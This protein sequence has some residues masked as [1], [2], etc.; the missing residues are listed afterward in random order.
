MI[1]IKRVVSLSLILIFCLSLTACVR[2]PNPDESV[3]ERPSVSVTIP[4]GFTILEIATRLEEKN[5]CSAADFIE[6][7]KTAPEGYGK[8]FNGI[9]T[10]NKIFA[11]EGYL[12]PNTYTFYENEDANKVL[13]RF[14]STFNAKLGEALT[15]DETYGGMDCYSKATELGMSMAEVII[16]ASVIQAEAN[17]DLSTSEGI[18]EMKKVSSVFHNRLNNPSKGFPYLG[19]DVTR[20]YIQYKMKSYI[21]EN[22][23]DYDAL[24]ALYCTNNGYSLKTKGLPKGPICNPS[25]S[26]IIAALWP[27]ETNYFYFFTD[28]DGNFHYFTNYDDFKKEWKIYKH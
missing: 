16:F 2:N 5:I 9:E 8:L 20:H 3:T 4:P 6:V 10:E 26:A 22:D 21:E 18:E 23:L 17:V 11:V 13:A 1:I 12:Y 27:A 7:C 28:V 15:H 25:R 14:L 19:S 24:F